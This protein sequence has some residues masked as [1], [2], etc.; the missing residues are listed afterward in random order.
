MPGDEYGKELTERP[1]ATA[2]EALQPR[3]YRDQPLSQSDVDFVAAR[4]QHA[5]EELPNAS[6]EVCGSRRSISCAAKQDSHTQWAHR[7]R[8]YR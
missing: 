1:R 3:T 6:S 2:Q 7:A 8:V 4:V 5:A